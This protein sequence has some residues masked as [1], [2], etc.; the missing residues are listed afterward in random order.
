MEKQTPGTPLP[1]ALANN[2]RQLG[3]YPKEHK[4][5]IL[6]LS[7][8]N[9][10]SSVADEK[11]CDTNCILLLAILGIERIVLHCLLQFWSNQAIVEIFCHSL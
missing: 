5:I 2:F 11:H 8:K 9:V 3:G 6:S 7:F 4:I 1:F 10:P